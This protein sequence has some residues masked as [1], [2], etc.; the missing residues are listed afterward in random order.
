MEINTK[1]NFMKVESKDLILFTLGK[2]DQLSEEVLR[3]IK[4]G[5]EHL[6]ILKIIF[7]ER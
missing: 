6:L 3:T 7:Q 4:C 2:M 5:K 1:V